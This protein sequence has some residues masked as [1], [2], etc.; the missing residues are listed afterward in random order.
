MRS[1]PADA[2]WRRTPRGYRRRTAS[3]A[4]ERLRR[5]LAPHVVGGVLRRRGDR[6][7][8]LAD[9]GALHALDA[10]LGLLV[11]LDPDGLR[12]LALQQRRAL[13]DE[14]PLLRLAVDAQ[15]ARGL[16]VNEE[17]GDVRAVLTAVHPEDQA[18]LED[19]ASGLAALEARGAQGRRGVLRRRRRRRGGGAC[20]GRRGGG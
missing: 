4:V 17:L 18:L 8:E 5:R 1:R 7:L 6:E 11:Q 12:D 20:G 15:L 14:H 10:A 13:A 9:V 3:S 16:A 19:R 2:P